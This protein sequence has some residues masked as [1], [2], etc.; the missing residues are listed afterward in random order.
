V[1]NQVF[2]CASFSEF[3]SGIWSAAGGSKAPAIYKQQL[4]VV[5]NEWFGVAAR[6]NIT[7]VWVYTSTVTDWEKQL[8]ADVKAALD[9][10]KH[11]PNYGTLDTELSPTEIN[12]LASLTAW[13]IANDNNKSLFID[14]YR[15]K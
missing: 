5:V 1:H 7:L 14:L 9:G 10:L 11:F 3:L 12:L 4:S 15:D 8:N 13:T 6:D 2:P